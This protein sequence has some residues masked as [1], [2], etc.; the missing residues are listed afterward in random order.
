[1]FSIFVCLS[2]LLFIVNKVNI[3]G[4]QDAFIF[5][6][7]T[8]SS[9]LSYCQTTDERI[10]WESR[11]RNSLFEENKL[12]SKA[13]FQLKPFNKLTSAVLSVS[14]SKSLIK[15]QLFVGLN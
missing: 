6:A 11:L 4:G 7:W 12:I 13:D 14:R 1:M 9:L 5:T 15:L 10:P 8:N 2:Y 3:P